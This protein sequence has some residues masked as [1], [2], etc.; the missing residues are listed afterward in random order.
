MFSLSS[1]QRQVRG[2]RMSNWILRTVVLAAAS[3][4]S[5]GNVMAQD[6]DPAGGVSSPL[7]YT[8]THGIKTKC[9][10]HEDLL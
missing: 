8:L 1:Y 9:L 3:V 2:R 5:L 6:G 4:L 7:F 10:E